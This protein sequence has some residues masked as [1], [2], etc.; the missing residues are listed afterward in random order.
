MKKNNKKGWIKIVEAF[1]A[2]VLLMGF[3]FVMLGQINKNND[4]T[5]LTEENNIKIL[6]GIETNQS[7]RNLV[8]SADVPSYS[9]KTFPSDLENYLGNSTLPGQYCFLYICG[10]ESECNF[11][12]NINS[13]VFSSEILITSNATVYNPRKLKVFCYDN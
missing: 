10:A 3:L 4:K 2:I 1:M 12:E 8:L 7:L 6:N 5:Y 11:K 13:N 9:N